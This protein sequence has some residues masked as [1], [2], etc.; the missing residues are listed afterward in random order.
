M[1]FQ[2][3]QLASGRRFRVG[4]ATP[5]VPAPAGTPPRPAPGGRLAEFNAVGVQEIAA[6]RGLRRPRRKACR[7]PRDA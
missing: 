4:Q 5:P 1:G 7:P 2:C 3:M 6:Q